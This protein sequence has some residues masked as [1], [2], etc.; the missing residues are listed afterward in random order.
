MNEES[1]MT[2]SHRTGILM[3]AAIVAAAAGCASALGQAPAPVA[4]AGASAAPV[5]IVDHAG[6]EPVAWARFGQCQFGLPIKQDDVT[7]LSTAVDA[8]AHEANVQRC[9]DKAVAERVNVL[10]LPELGLAVPAAMRERIVAR[11]QKAAADRD[12]VIIAGSYYDNDRY[13]RSVVIGRG[14]IE[15]GYKVRPSRFEASPRA[16]MG[17][18]EGKHVLL[19][20][21]RYG[22]FA[23]VVCVD[24]ISDEVQYALRELA[25]R[26]ELDVI[27][28]VN[29]NPA[30]WEFLIEA[31]SFVRRHPVF[32]SITNVT[33][34]PEGTHCMEN[35]KPHD[36][37]VC[38]GHTA[39]F[40]DAHTD[41][42]EFP[43]NVQTM[44][45]QLPADFLSGGKPALPFDHL[46][47]DVGAF[48]EGLLVYELNLRLNREPATANA[49]DQGYPTIR[50]VHVVDL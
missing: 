45:R 17:M 34:A 31:N 42:G 50:D 27:V 11:L 2:R 43:N 20:R 29:Y 35:G 21:T 46:V 3:L 10:V 25:T 40:A 14:W 9:L 33:A 8:N 48:R 5:R 4:R 41:A 1:I 22:R 38:F 18:R 30:A 6:G 49:P 26:G 39:V 47:G 36:D 32:A 7:G 16:G 23:V 19:V 15:E 28:N 37:G 12:M 13:S 44:A 24:L